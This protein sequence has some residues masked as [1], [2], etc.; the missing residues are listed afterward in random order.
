MHTMFSQLR[1]TQLP[2]KSSQ[3]IRSSTQ[4]I[5]LKLSV[6]MLPHTEV[7]T[8]TENCS[9]IHFDA[10]G[11]AFLNCSYERSCN[12]RLLCPGMNCQQAETQRALLRIS[13]LTFGPTLGMQTLKSNP[14]FEIKADL[15]SQS[16]RWKPKEENLKA[17]K[18]TS[19]DI[20]ALCRQIL[21]L[22]PPTPLEF[23]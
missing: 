1:V 7:A 3:S 2:L 12:F 11:N 5:C 13:V 6:P 8:Q 18:N 22:P 10:P 23:A 9:L 15:P 16:T 17:G 20:S 19:L 4:S 14:H 21:G